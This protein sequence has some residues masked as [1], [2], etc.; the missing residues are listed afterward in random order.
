MSQSKHPDIKTRKGNLISSTASINTPEI[1]MRVGWNG[2]NPV[3]SIA[4]GRQ[5]KVSYP[6]RVGSMPAVATNI[7]GAIANGP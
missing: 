3:D 2:T 4:G 1:P 5:R 6:N 7:I